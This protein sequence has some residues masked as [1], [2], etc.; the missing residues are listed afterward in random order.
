M[1]WAYGVGVWSGRVEW[2]TGKSGCA[3]VTRRSRRN[4]G[5]LRMIADSWLTMI[6]SEKDEDLM[7]HQLKKNEALSHTKS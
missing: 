7:Q 5:I 2:A 3:V 1:Q 4:T 6:P